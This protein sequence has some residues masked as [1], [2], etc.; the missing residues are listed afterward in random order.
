MRAT[1]AT[2]RPYFAAARSSDELQRHLD[3][4]F[5]PDQLGVG[6]DPHGRVD[7]LSLGHD[8]RVRLLLGAC[9]LAFLAV[10]RTTLAAAAFL[11][12]SSR[13]SLALL[14]ATLLFVVFLIRSATTPALKS[15]A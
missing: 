5:E 11:L 9:L 1:W 7:G 3:A 12:A 10:A 2:A 6:E 4:L 15:P 13:P 8:V 14:V